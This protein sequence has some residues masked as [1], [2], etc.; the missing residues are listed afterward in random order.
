MKILLISIITFLASFG[1]SIATPSD[2]ISL[3]HHSIGV[4]G[5]M[6]TGFGISYRYNF[7]NNYYI[8]T[9][10]AAYFS[11]VSSQDRSFI[12]F[13]G[14]EFQKNLI[15]T[16]STRLYGFV[17]GSYWFDE[18]RNINTDN[19]TVP[20]IRT[21]DTK[22]VGVGFSFEVSV[23]NHFL[24]NLDFGFQYGGFEHV[25]TGDHKYNR[26]STRTGMSGGL[27]FGYQF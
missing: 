25:T 16:A 17:G 27:G 23:W 19:S 26:E 18:S 4:S 21:E 24:L 15:Q 9:V 13:I 14:L 3:M 20:N 2:S 1:F 12:G 10:G 7:D 6:I 8:K 22:N 5:S 11:G